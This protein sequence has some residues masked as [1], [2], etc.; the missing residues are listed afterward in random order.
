M[1]GQRRRSAAP[2]YVELSMRTDLD[3]LWELTQQPWLHQRWDGRFSRIDYLHPPEPQPPGGERR[4][5]P[6]RFRYLLGPARGPALTGTGV[7]TAERWRADGQRVGALRFVADS[8]WSPL[9]E[10]AGYW[11]YLPE[12][13]APDGVPTVTF[14]TGYDYRS[15]PWPGGAQLDRWLVRPFVGWLTA[16]SFDRLRLWAE[17]GVSPERALRHCLGEIAARAGVAALAAWGTAAATG[18]PAAGVLTAGAL[19]ALS[20]VVPRPASL[21]P[22]AAAGGARNGGRPVRRSCWPPSPRRPQRTAPSAALAPSASDSTVRHSRR[23]PRAPWSRYDHHRCRPVRL[24]RRHPDPVDLP[25]GARQGFR[26]AASGVAA[27]VRLLQCGR[28]RLH[29]YGADG[30]DRARVAPTGAVAVGGDAA[31]HPVSGAGPGGAVHDRQ[32]R[33]PGRVRAGD[34]DVRADVPVHPA[35]ALRR[36]DGRGAGA[37]GDG[38]R[39]SG[40][41]SA[42]GGGSAAGG[43]A[44]RRAGDLLGGAPGGLAG[45]CAGAAGVA[46]GAGGS[47]R[48]VRRG[49]GSVSDP[50]AGDQSGGGAGAGVPGVV[51]GGV[52]AG[53]GGGGSA[54]C[55]SGP[56]V[57]PGVAGCGRPAGAA[58]GYA[59]A[60]ERH[61]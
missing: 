10:G 15:W 41:A 3:T 21:R 2:I 35:A 39:L 9:Q 11:R 49:G 51:H 4:G 17:R 53:G 52:P 12:T 57:R 36:D 16:W 61:T 25:C 40:D 13:V 8:G 29:R 6:V 55:A 47:A 26:P 50:G 44:A 19:L 18:R 34:G 45:R 24:P 27:P 20:A 1:P 33:V 14:V 23:R 22:R 56:R 54:S 38:A 7:T 5:G 60:H 37:A 42:P 48:V 28:D 46:D 43:D 31:E 32:L 59:A 30:A 58:D